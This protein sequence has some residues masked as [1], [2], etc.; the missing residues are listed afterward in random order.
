MAL[1]RILIVRRRCRTQSRA[2][3]AA[4]RLTTGK[5]AK[6]DVTEKKVAVAPPGARFRPSDVA[7]P[8]W[9]P[10]S[11]CASVTWEGVFGVYLPWRCA[12]CGLPDG[13]S[14]IGALLPEAIVKRLSAPIRTHPLDYTTMPIG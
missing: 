3:T 5:L 8:A 11:A 4:P 13:L 6:T 1:C 12:P 10:A 7:G 9:T 14:V 2:A